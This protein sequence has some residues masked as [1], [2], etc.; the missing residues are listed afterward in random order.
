MYSSFQFPK[1]DIN[2]SSVKFQATGCSGSRGEQLY[3]FEIE[4]YSDIDA[5]VGFEKKICNIII[6]IRQTSSYRINDRE[7]N[8][9]LKKKKTD[10]NNSWPRLTKASAKLP[11]LKVIINNIKSSFSSA[12][13]QAD[14]DKMTFSE[15]ESDQGEQKKSMFVREKR[16]VIYL[17]HFIVLQ[18]NDF[19]DD[20]YKSFRKDAHVNKPTGNK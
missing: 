18:N 2:E 12:F 5:K 15:D 11:W 8:V 3:S 6:I 17:F 14:F 13:I 20:M 16:M 9:N 4:L 1:V 19:N 10:T 7:I